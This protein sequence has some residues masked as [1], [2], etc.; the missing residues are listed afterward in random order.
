MKGPSLALAA[1][2]LIMGAVWSKG[3]TF[4]AKWN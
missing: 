1:A 3:P 2:A 4:S